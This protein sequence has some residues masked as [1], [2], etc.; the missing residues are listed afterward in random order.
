MARNKDDDAPA[1]VVTPR[2]Q[3]T[4]RRPIDAVARAKY[5]DVLVRTGS[6]SAAAAA[7]RPHLRTK[8]SAMSVFENHMA[9]NPAFM[10]QVLDAEARV[11]GELDAEIIRRAMEGVVVYEKYAV[12]D[13]GERELVERRVD[14][15]NKLLVQVARNVGRRVN[16]TAWA[17]DDKRVVVEG[18]TTNVSVAVDLDRVLEGMSSDAIRSLVD[19]AGKARLMA[20]VEDGDAEDADVLD[21]PLDN[22][23][24]G[25]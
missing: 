3:I 5:L 7:A 19:A 14:H 22:G 25:N 16:P 12:N 9:S 6:R 11:A 24:H 10:A 8:A 1:I 4:K 21:L 18:G 2:D 20:P 23:S 13:K 17:P 15:D